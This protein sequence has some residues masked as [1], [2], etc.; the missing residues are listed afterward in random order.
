MLSSVE[1]KGNMSGKIADR[2][3]KF[4]LSANKFNG[5]LSVSEIEADDESNNNQSKFVS[6]VAIESNLRGSQNGYELYLNYYKVE[7]IAL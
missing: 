7:H 3:H 1:S 4:S 6:K 5:N 2:I